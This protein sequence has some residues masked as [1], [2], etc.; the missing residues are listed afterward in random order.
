MYSNSNRVDVPNAIKIDS[1][2]FMHLCS[3]NQEKCPFYSKVCDVHTSFAKQDIYKFFTCD[4]LDAW[5]HNDNAN[6]SCMAEVFSSVS[7]IIFYAGLLGCQKFQ[8][9]IHQNFF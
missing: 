1:K 8:V 2:D 6:I 3:L 9:L 4:T 7:E 5:T